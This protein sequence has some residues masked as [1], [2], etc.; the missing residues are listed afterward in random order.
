MAPPT[1]P[2][3]YPLRTTRT[4]SVTRP[5]SPST[6]TSSREGEDDTYTPPTGELEE[7]HNHARQYQAVTTSRTHL[8]SSR[9]QP[10]TP[11]PRQAARPRGRPRKR[12]RGVSRQRQSAFDA[13]VAAATS[14]APTG[15]SAAPPTE[16]ATDPAEPAPAQVVAP[17]A[18]VGGWGGG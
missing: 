16:S 3:R 8:Q 2:R 7:S 14:P 11:R 1:T 4:T 15:G 6:S 13:A 17:V 10:S 12:P 5:P 9:E 18:L